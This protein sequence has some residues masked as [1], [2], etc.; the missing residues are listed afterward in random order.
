VRPKGSS[1]AK[2]VAQG[3]FLKIILK[4]VKIKKLSSDERGKRSRRKILQAGPAVSGC[5]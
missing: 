2:K 5:G 3:L 1:S 4:K